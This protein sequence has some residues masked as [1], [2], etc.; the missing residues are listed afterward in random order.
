MLFRMSQA[1]EKASSASGY[2]GK[3]LQQWAGGVVDG[4]VDGVVVGGIEKVESKRFRRSDFTFINM[5]GDGTYSHVYECIHLETSTR[6]AMKIITKNNKSVD[7][8][9]VV[10][11][12]R[13]HSSLKHPNIVRVFGCFY[14]DK[15]CC[16]AMEL[17]VPLRN[18][19]DNEIL[20][21]DVI[22]NIMA[23]L[24][25]AITYI[26]SSGIIHRDLKPDN[27]IMVM[28]IAKICDF[29]MAGLVINPENIKSTHVYGT[30][31]Y[32]AP[33]ILEYKP[34][35]TQSDLW[36]LGIL[37]YE[38]YLGTPPYYD[39][40]LSQTVKNIKQADPPVFSKCHNAVI[41]NYVSSL[42][43]KE[44]TARKLYTGCNF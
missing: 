5:L 7:P 34:H 11:E 6:V 29:G 39:E 12:I 2:D 15:M 16:I 23:D 33:E 35:T 24:T 21:I 43:K 19:I 41:S 20:A 44:P 4:V 31:D 40:K 17:G 37:I 25:V 3:Y 38:V 14:H 8:L 1:F 26:H 36:S 10:N 22:L 9:D 27:I 32:V 42:L 18:I 30:I 28:N 13:I